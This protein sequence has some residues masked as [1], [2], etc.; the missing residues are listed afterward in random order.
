MARY[1]AKDTEYHGHQLK[2]G[3]MVLLPFPAA[4]RDPRIFDRPQEV[5]LDRQ[6]NRHYAFG[7]G[8]HRCLGSNLARME[9]R[10]GLQAFLRRIPNFEI[11]Q[12]ER[13][14]YAGGNIRGPRTLP[15]VMQGRRSESLA[16]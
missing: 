13:V 11:P 12:G 6:D 9:V 1:V 14:H 15:L 8:I 16:V 4:N 3:D 10:V 2:E 7:V 5:V